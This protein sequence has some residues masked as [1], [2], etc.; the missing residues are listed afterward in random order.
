MGIIPQ[1]NAD[2]KALAHNYGQMAD[3][4]RAFL[5]TLTPDTSDNENT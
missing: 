5:D 2:M 4:W 1:F 3:G